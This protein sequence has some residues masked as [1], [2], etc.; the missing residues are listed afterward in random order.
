M[1]TIILFICSLG[2]GG[3][4]HQ[5]VILSR[6]LVERGYK[7][8]IVTFSDTPDHY[9]ISDGIERIRLGI[10]KGRFRQLYDILKYFFSVKTD[11]VISFG[12]RENLF[13]LMSLLFRPQIKVIAGE[14]N[15]T[16]G[17]PTRIEKI[18]H[19]LLYKRANWIVPNSY[20]Q[21][22]YIKEHAP[23]F[24]NKV[25]TIINY[26][27][28]SIYSAVD[29]PYNSPLRFCLFCRYHPQK[30]Y[31]RFAKAV[32]RVIDLGY[33]GFTIDWYG[34]T[35]F[36][37]TYVNN[38]YEKLSSLIQELGIKKVLHLHDKISDVSS[39]MTKC[40]AVILPSLF[41]GFS[42]TISETICCGRPCICGNVA[43][44]GIM[45]HDGINGYLFNPEDIED[46]SQTIIKFLKLSNEERATMC[47]ESR[48]IAESLFNK[49]LF[50]DKY[51]DLIEN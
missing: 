49:R 36:K 22:K 11:V 15:T 5:L 24:A 23:K 13:C 27:D 31:E 44:N 26:T 9:S 33:N 41:E 2:S 43:D 45:V 14:R 28:L 19:K 4:E 34:E 1:K 17:K 6:F 18:L 47:K 46:M 12:Q 35:K 39:E 50:T 38:H 25:Q 30:N 37:N 32:R 10:N 8:R 51:V 48:K 42:N 7:V 20:S 21:G 29:S 16:Y 3:A 40:D